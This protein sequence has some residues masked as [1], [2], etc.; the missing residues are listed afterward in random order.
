[1]FKITAINN[2][3]IPYKWLHELSN[4]EHKNVH[5][6]TLTATIFTQLVFETAVL[7]LYYQQDKD[8]APQHMELV[9]ERTV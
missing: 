3:G 1:M 9:R 6:Y 2:W 5:V 4:F 8:T 7:I